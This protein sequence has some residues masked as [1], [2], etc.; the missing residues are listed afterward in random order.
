LTTIKKIN[1]RRLDF[2]SDQTLTAES[3]LGFELWQ[4]LSLLSLVLI[5]ASALV[6][7]SN[8]RSLGSGN[9]QRLLNQAK[10][11]VFVDFQAVDSELSKPIRITKASNPDECFS[12]LQSDVGDFSQIKSKK[13]LI[14]QTEQSLQQVDEK[15]ENG[16]Q[17]WQNYIK[18]MR[19]YLS[20][21]K[22]VVEDFEDDAVGI[23]K[24][25]QDLSKYCVKGDEKIL[26]SPDFEQNLS[27]LSQS[28]SQTSKEFADKVSK[29]IRDEGDVKNNSFLELFVQPRLDFEES[30][31]TETQS[32]NL[33]LRELEKTERSQVGQDEARELNLI[34]IQ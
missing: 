22:T 33:A 29:W 8:S 12:H 2:L 13:E 4:I 21:A 15:V 17:N 28:Q 6:W 18:S 7:F 27:F 1:D 20:K 34:F 3:K 5:I 24:V 26:N 19:S 11:E 30:L 9:K 16:S 10:A 14:A 32:F 25:Q 23:L 31:K